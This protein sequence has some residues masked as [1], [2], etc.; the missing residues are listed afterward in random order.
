MR[1]A[2]RDSVIPLAMPQKTKTGEIITSIPV[3]K[4]QHIFCSFAAYNR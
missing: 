1:M 4:G 3:S 2:G